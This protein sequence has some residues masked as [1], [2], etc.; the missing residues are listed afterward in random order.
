MDAYAKEFSPVGYSSGESVI[1][2]S[3]AQNVD[4]GVCVSPGQD[5]F[6]RVRGTLNGRADQ[7]YNA[8]PDDG[9]SNFGVV[10]YPFGIVEAKS[11]DPAIRVAGKPAKNGAGKTAG[12]TRGTISGGGEVGN[13]LTPH[14]EITNITGTLD[15]QSES[16][17]TRRYFGQLD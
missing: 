5:F 15:G 11:K 4:Y 3:D 8:T 7:I 14:D 17:V 2:S 9:T 12:F 6:G 13:T 16:S 1:A 10:N